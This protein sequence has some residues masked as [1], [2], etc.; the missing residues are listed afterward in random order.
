MI[1]L[2]GIEKRYDTDARPALSR[3]DLELGGGNTILIG[4][5]GAGKSTLFRVL[6][7]LERPTSGEVRWRASGRPRI[8]YA[9]ELPALPSAARLDELFR[10]VDPD[11]CRSRDCVRLFQLDSVLRRRVERLSR[12]ERQRSSLALAFATGAPLLILDEPF[13]GLDP[14][15]RP[16]VRA[17]IARAL[18]NQPD[19]VVLASTHRIEEVDA[20]FERIIVLHEGFVIQDLSLSRLRELE[21]ASLIAFDPAVEPE[22]IYETIAPCV[23]A[24]RSVR[25]VHG[26]RD[27][28]PVVLGGPFLDESVPAGLGKRAGLEGLLQVWLGKSVTGEEK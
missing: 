13:E 15:V 20:P 24:G 16:L 8:G 17:G 4:P 12:G 10:I 23:P 7:G 27:N 6:L 22:R 11:R 26:Y 9:P 2:A 5:N 18:A 1:R 25:A 19:T 21:G 3:L 28:A 14:I